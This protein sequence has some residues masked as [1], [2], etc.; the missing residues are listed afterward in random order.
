MPQLQ[1]EA[2][3]LHLERARDREGGS[4]LLGAPTIGGGSAQPWG[5]GEGSQKSYMS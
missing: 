4:K 2:P 5:G 1:S 3:G